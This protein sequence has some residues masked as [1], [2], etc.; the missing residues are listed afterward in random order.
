[1]DLVPESLLVEQRAA[2]S[3][4]EARPGPRPGAFSASELRRSRLYRPDG[5]SR[6]SLAPEATDQVVETE[7]GPMP[8]R[9]FPGV[10]AHGTVVHFHGGGWVLGSMHEQDGLLADLA[11]AAGVRVLSL[12]YPLAP[13]TALPATLDIA[14]AALDALAA[15]AISPVGV[16]GESAGAH[17]ALC[18]ALVAR[19]RPGMAGRIGAL[20]LNYGIY[21][22]SM[23]PSQR[24]WGERFLGLSTPWLEWFY[25]QALPGM[26]RD[27][28]SDPHLS[29]LY[30]DL[31][32]LPPVLLSVGSLDPLLD[33]S[34]FL[35]ERLRAAGAQA[36]LDIYPEAP[37]GFNHGPTGL[38]RRCNENVAS[39]FRE[40]LG[41]RS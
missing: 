17:L 29:P 10:G 25:A 36:A 19:N 41:P 12:G 24:T 22:L 33:D 31:Q 11:A 35:F 8:Y 20:A 30:A 13:E 7:L 26:S 32:G 38:A 39:F 21:D 6:L 27:Q 3:R 23:T 1:M 34:T 28:R 15:A 18:S 9:L 2:N 16:M 5:S 37:H 14:A 40:R 4:A